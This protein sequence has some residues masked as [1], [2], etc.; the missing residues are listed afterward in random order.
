[1]HQGGIMHG[2]IVLGLH[3]WVN[4]RRTNTICAFIFN[5]MLNNWIRSDCLQ[6]KKKKYGHQICKRNAWREYIMHN[7]ILLGS[8]IWPHISALTQPVQSS[9]SWKIKHTCS[10]R[11]KQSQNYQETLSC[12][13]MPKK[14]E[15]NKEKYCCRNALKMNKKSSVLHTYIQCTCYLIHEQTNTKECIH[16]KLNPSKINKEATPAQRWSSA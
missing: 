12:L 15:H 4:I 6:N 5:F 10:W 13:N 2:L 9:C 11:I 7:L 14:S 1:M 3:S 8:L 16:L